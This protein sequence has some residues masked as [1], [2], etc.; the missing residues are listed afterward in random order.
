[1]TDFFD[2]NLAQ[3]TVNTALKQMDDGELFL[4]STRSEQ[5]AL[6]DGLLRTASF[7]S[8]T[9][10]GLRAIKGETVAYAH[11]S[12]FSPA[13]FKNAADVV[14]SIQNSDVSDAVNRAIDTVDSTQPHALYTDQDPLL[15]ADTPVKIELLQAM[16]AYARDKDS[17]VVQVMASL[18][19]EQQIVHILRPD[20]HQQDIRPLVRLNVSV[21]LEENG[22]RESGGTGIGGR[23]DYSALLEKS[24]WQR[25]VD[26]A[27]RMA[28]VNL[29]AVAAPAGE[30]PVVLGNGWTGVLLHEAVGHGLE[31]DFNR[32]KTSTFTDSIGKQVASRGITIVDDGT[33]PHRRGSITIDDEGTLP[34]Y[35]TLIEDGILKGY[36]QDRLNA[37]LMDVAPTGNGRR[38]SYQHTPMPRMTN[39]Y[40]LNGTDSREDM[41]ASVENG[42]Y[43]AN[44]GGGQ[45]DITNGQ[46]VFSASEAY[47]IEKGK[48]T[49]PVKGITLIGNG[50]AIMQ[51]IDMVGN[52]SELDKGVGTCGKDGQ[53][54]PVGVGQP[55]VKIRE[56]MVGGTAV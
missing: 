14:Q 51:K 38:E 2:K 18:S 10:F 5:F 11:A 36:L 31:G 12:E 52:D 44:F 33:I 22:R 30:M 28:R 42:I 26:E 41:I 1:M 43:A 32:K 34:G 54:V 13:A 3:E 40:M 39:T 16:D 4:E 24:N 20:S 9:G 15:S 29:S 19:G 6:D 55:S 8:A 25:L 27:L 53:S 35:N 46:F 56:I 50:P 47:K 49:D 45:V 21:I 23:Y 48:I 7:N 17:R 37:R